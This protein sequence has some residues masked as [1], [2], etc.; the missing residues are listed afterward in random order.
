[1]SS[2]QGYDSALPFSLN[3]ICF[4]P[5]IIKWLVS[6]NRDITRVW[7]PLFCFVAWKSVHCHMRFSSA[8]DYTLEQDGRL[9]LSI[10][11]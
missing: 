8:D 4:H 11:P 1:V 2:V 10:V 6:L 7:K 3:S 5:V 9:L